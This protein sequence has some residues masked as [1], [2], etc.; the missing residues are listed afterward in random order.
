MFFLCSS[1]LA[2]FFMLKDG[3]S[4][5]RWVDRHL[6]VPVPV[7]QTVTRNVV[8]SLRRYFLGVTI[9][10]VFNGI[11]VGVAAILLEFRSQARSP[12]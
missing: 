8:N 11:I 9:V 6:G 5:R 4:V 7:A 2:T 3:P 12:S 1:L 10:A